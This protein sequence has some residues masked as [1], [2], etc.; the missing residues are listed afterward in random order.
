MTGPS[1][2]R[3]R[4]NLYWTGQTRFTLDH[5]P[6]MDEQQLVEADGPEGDA[7]ETWRASKAESSW[8]E[9]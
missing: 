4:P 1:D 9:A 6:V 3:R 2:R 8:Q 5:T 7:A